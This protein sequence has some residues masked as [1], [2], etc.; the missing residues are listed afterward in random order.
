MEVAVRRPTRRQLTRRHPP[1]QSLPIKAPARPALA[2]HLRI[3]RPPGQELD[4]RQLTVARGHDIRGKFPR[5]SAAVIS[6]KREW[7]ITVEQPEEEEEDN[8]TS[9]I[10]IWDLDSPDKA[11]RELT[12]HQGKIT[13][14]E[15]GG[16]R[17]L[18]G[19]ST[20]PDERYLT[21]ATN[22]HVYVWDLEDGELRY[23]FASSGPVAFSPDSS[24]LK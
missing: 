21:G 23:T 18:V 15:D 12:G 17:N 11:I 2:P 22:E 7:I 20:S 14:Q 4:L 10:K 1:I 13:D 16:T 3:L 24:R 8:D 5:L 9:I 19:L 6:P